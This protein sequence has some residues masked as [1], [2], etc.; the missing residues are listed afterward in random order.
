[1][2]KTELNIELD[3]NK[4]AAQ[5]KSD[6]TIS[7][8]VNVNYDDCK[9]ASET[10]RPVI[11]A[12]AADTF[13]ALLSAILTK[14]NVNAV[15]DMLNVDISELIGNIDGLNE[16]TKN[17]LIDTVNNAIENPQYLIG[18][19]INILNGNY[20]VEGVP[21]LYYFLGEAAYDYT[22][23]YGDNWNKKVNDTIKKLDAIIVNLIPSLLPMFANADKPADD[24]MNVIANSGADDL[25]DIVDTLLNNFVL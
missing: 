17:I 13:I 4:I 23:D 9:N 12:D 6:V 1:L 5:S 10:A 25:T 16:E 14:E 15:L 18:I 11:D 19:I 20:D 22:G 21:F 3:F 24:I 8:K 7:S 2:S